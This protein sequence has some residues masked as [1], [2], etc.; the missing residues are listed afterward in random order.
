MFS[1]SVVSA[2]TTIYLSAE[3]QDCYPLPN[4]RYMIHQPL[5]GF[6]G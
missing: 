6:N 2:G 1:F 3:K 4:T 5:G